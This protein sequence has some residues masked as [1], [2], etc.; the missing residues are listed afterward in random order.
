MG[1]GNQDRR[2]RLAFAP[3]QTLS[4]LM[5]SGELHTSRTMETQTTMMLKRPIC[6]L[7]E[8]RYDYIF[9]SYSCMIGNNRKHCCFS[10]AQLDCSDTLWQ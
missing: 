6:T 9:H 3:W 5:V 1:T 10:L 7:V 8:M 4:F 2:S